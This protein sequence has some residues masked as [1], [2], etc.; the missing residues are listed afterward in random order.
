MTVSQPELLLN[1]LGSIDEPTSL[2]ALKIIK[3]GV[4][5]NR[6]RKE[7]FISVGVL[8][9]LVQL[10]ESIQTSN[11]VKAQA[12]IVLGSLAYGGRDHVASIVSAGAIIPLID[13]LSCRD[14]PILLEASARALK[15][16]F[17]SGGP[18]IDLFHD[19]YLADLA[20]TL[21]ICFNVKLASE[22]ERAGALQIAELACGIIAR[23]CETTEQQS[24][25]AEAGVIDSLSR[26]LN[27][28]YAKVQE[29]AM[30]ALA[31]LC[32]D[33][34]AIGAAIVDATNDNMEAPVPIMLRLV[35]DKSPSMRLMAATW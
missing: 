9:R 18:K 24:M 21:T 28:P 4:I 6:T 15:A 33:N 7:Q 11:H 5:G 22:K 30:D 23:T 26:L 25:M 12:A 14:D 8:P 17:S 3:N 32:R 34:Q 29:A 35:R 13:C 16:V 27:C 2:S 20:Y 19:H 1:Q 31:S 10:L